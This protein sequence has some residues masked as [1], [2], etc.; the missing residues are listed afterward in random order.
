MNFDG[1]DPSII[2]PALAAG[3]LV[4]ATHVPMGQQVLKRG[5]IFIDLAIAQ[6]AALG[7]LLAHSIGFEDSTVAVQ[8][9][10]PL[11]KLEP[12]LGFTRFGLCVTQPGN[13]HLF[14]SSFPPC[15]RNV[16]TN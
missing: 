10:A 11:R 4:T 6:I 3:V 5:I 15:F 2:A 9:T 14:V 1:L 16:C 7:V 12:Y 13:K 8:V